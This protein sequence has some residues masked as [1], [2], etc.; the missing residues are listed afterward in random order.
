VETRQLLSQLL[1]EMKNAKLVQFIVKD[2]KP[3]V[4]YRFHLMQAAIHQVTTLGHKL[5]IYG[6]KTY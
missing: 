3:S 4:Y 6:I 2:S 5:P 1:S